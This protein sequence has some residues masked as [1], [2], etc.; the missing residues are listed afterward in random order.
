LP[1][2]PGERVLQ[3]VRDASGHWSAA[4]N[5]TCLAISAAKRPARTIRDAHTHGTLIR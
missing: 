1:I 5:T 4:S 2:E 3:F